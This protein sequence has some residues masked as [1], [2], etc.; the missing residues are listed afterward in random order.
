MDPDEEFISV[1]TDETV[2]DHFERGEDVSEVEH[3]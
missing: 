3:R 2:L 1:E